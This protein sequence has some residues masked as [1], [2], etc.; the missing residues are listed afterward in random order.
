MMKTKIFAAALLA[1][2]LALPSLADDA[3]S[4]GWGRDFA[5]EIEQG[6]SHMVGLEYARALENYERAE[7]LAPHAA[8]APYKIAYALYRWGN[9]VPVRRED[10]WPLAVRK[11]DR[12]LF[13]DRTSAD[14]TFLAG[15]IRYRLGDFRSA[16]EVYKA[17]ETVRQGDVDL[18]LDLAVAAWRGG[19][20]KLAMAALDRA[21]LIA[22]SSRRLH[23]LAR[24][25]LALR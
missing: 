20:M 16:V 4:T 7:K 18:Y 1:A 17:L 10:L 11:A 12:A 23:A 8:I 15:V 9:D 24:E 5:S 19:D 2:C 13:L 25:I 21:R 22:P 3:A 14:A 6:D